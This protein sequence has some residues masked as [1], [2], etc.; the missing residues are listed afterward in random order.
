MSN[1]T[2][3]V[4]V[5]GE[6]W[7][8]SEEFVCAVNRF[9]CL[10]CCQPFGCVH[11]QLF[12][13]CVHCITTVYVRVHATSTI[14]SEKL[15]VITLF[16]YGAHNINHFV[17]GRTSRNVCDVPDS[18][19]LEN[20]PHTGFCLETICLGVWVRFFRGSQTL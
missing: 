17:N 4:R 14:L 15:T 1:T 16:V 9:G 19:P 5:S 18:K 11:A 20:Q 3:L 13:L 6:L 12:F 2:Y 10:R 7:C 8:C